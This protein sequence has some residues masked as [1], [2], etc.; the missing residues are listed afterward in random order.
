MAA[1]I[2]AAPRAYWAKCAAAGL[3]GGA[4]M[5]LYLMVTSA[6]EG[7]GLWMPV[8]TIGATIPAFRPPSFAI[9]PA[10]GFVAGPSVTGLVLHLVVSALWGMFYGM[11]VGAFVPRRVRSFGWET[12]YAVG[13]G[14]MLW[15]FSGLLFTRL[16]NPTMV[17]NLAGSP[18]Y[19]IGHLLFALVTA[20]LI[21]G[22]TTRS[23]VLITFAPESREAKELTRR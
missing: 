23:E 4:V 21:A 7:K 8:N 5:A 3:A 14:C 20:W 1:R 17:A 19:F 6:A 16:I 10:P 22:M 9:P 2:E 11:G 13:F 15:V 12:L 18:H